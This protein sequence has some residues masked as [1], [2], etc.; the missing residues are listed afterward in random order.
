[1]TVRSTSIEFERII[2]V[3]VLGLFPVQI[4]LYQ[5][6]RC[7]GDVVSCPEDLTQLEAY[8]YV[9]NMQPWRVEL[10]QQAGMTAYM[11]Q[12][13]DAAKEL[14]TIAEEK[15]ALDRQGKQ[16]LAEAHLNSGDTDTGVEHMLALMDKDQL[17]VQ[18]FR[19]LYDLLLAE[20]RIA[21]AEQVAQAWTAAEP[22]SADAQLRLGLVQLAQDHA[23]ALSNLQ[24][25]SALDSTLQPFVRDMDVAIAQAHLS[26]DSA[27]QQLLIGREL[28]N[29]GYTLYAE[30]LCVQAVKINPQYAEAWAMLGEMQQQNGRGDGFSALETAVDLDPQSTLVQ[31]LMAIYWQRKGDPSQAMTYYEQLSAQQPEEFRWQVEL[32]K[33]TADSGDIP[34]GYELMLDVQEAFAEETQ[35]WIDTANF[36]AAYGMDAA[37]VG[38]ASAK[39]ALSRDP[40]N[41]AAMAAMGNVLFALSDFDSAQRY[42]QRALE[43]D[44]QNAQLHFL[45]G[46]IY[47]EKENMELALYHLELAQVLVSQYSTLAVQIERTLESF[48]Q[49]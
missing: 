13:W 12:D 23:E 29:Q 22:Q 42:Y 48:Q 4:D 49:P 14:F 35:V 39:E 8:A 30:I 36:C 9:L 40:D 27:Y 19:P 21:E 34:A 15:N 24:L 5:A 25:A 6:G 46:K 45:L 18:D 1:M 31:S 38:L 3:L 44:P 33:A 28:A 32:A 7:I 47:I 17:P 10:W 20:F 26:D 37:T 41:V 2:L 11:L 43:T 16:L